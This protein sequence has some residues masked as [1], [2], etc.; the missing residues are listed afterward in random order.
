MIDLS[1]SGARIGQI[2]PG[3]NRAVWYVMATWPDPDRI[4]WK[5]LAWWALVITRPAP[6]PLT[7]AALPP[8]HVEALAL[9]DAVARGTHAA[10]KPA[11]VPS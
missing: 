7:P 6:A 3:T 9:Y 1:R 2:R 8:L 4:G 10:L 5:S 11:R